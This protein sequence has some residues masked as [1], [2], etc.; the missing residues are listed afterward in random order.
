MTDPVMLPTPEAI[1][2]PFWLFEIL[3][4]LLFY[5]H[6]LLVN[7]VLGGSLILLVTRLRGQSNEIGRSLV[8]SITNKLPTALAMAIT[9]GIAPLL[10][11][12]VV[13]GHLFYASS[14]LM[15]WWWLAI[16][17]VLI[18][19]YYGTYVHNRMGTSKPAVGTWAIGI[20]SLL[21][22]F[23]SFLYVN[24]LTLMEVPVDWQRYF[25]HRNGTLLHLAD[26]TFLPRW[27]HFIVASVAVAGLF[28]ALVWWM[29]ERKGDA[30]APQKVKNGLQ[31]FGYATIVQILVGF[32]WLIALPRPIMLEFMGGSMI[33]TVLLLLGILLA[34]GALVVALLNKLMP[35]LIHL[36][37]LGL[38]MVVMRVFLR[39]SYLRESFDPATLELKGQYGVL[40]L[41]FVVLAA[42][43]YAVYIMI[44]AVL[45]AEAGRTQS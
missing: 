18:I 44:K 14:V 22:L 28:M 17:P 21:F 27:L 11:V 43:L 5:I 36:L 25:D 13:Y 30:R 40:A 3:G 7:V 26:P 4:A 15:G 12:Q 1:P 23:V 45:K 2:A 37:T 33:R 32:W 9:I 16:V 29:R 35:T 20:S 34:V 10:F 6:I 19:A 8:G 39:Y 42:G 38:V 31:V 24:N 41:F